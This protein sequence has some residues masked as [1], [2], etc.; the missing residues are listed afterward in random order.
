[1]LA[2]ASSTSSVVKARTSDRSAACRVMLKKKGFPRSV[3]DWWRAAAAVFLLVQL[4]NMFLASMSIN[5]RGRL[6]KGEEEGGRVG[7]EAT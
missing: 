4:N 6:S 7:K 2:T 3:V 1:M 5:R